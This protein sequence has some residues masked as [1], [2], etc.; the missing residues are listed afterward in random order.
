MYTYIYIY[1]WEASHIFGVLLY[2]ARLFPMSSTW[3]V[4]TYMGSLLMYEKASHTWAVF[5]HIR[6]IPMYEKPS[7]IWEAIPY[8]GRLPILGTHV[9]MVV[10]GADFHNFGQM[11]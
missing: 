11:F 5:P 6:S 4:C 3:E 10:S 8:M 7:C 2:W 1:V 9:I